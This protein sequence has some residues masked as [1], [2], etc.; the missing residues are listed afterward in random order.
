MRQGIC[1]LR[2][3][4]MAELFLIFDIEEKNQNLGSTQNSF[5]IFGILE[6]SK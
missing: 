2:V 4:E 5:D 1:F 6:E 3:F